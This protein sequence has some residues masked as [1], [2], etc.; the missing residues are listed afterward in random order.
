MLPCNG[1]LAGQTSP[2]TKSKFFKVCEKKIIFNI[3]D[4]NGDV[5]LHS[6]AKV[7]FYDFR[8]EEA[9]DLYVKGK[10]KHFIISQSVLKIKL[11]LTL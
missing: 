1:G 10:N 3:K 7:P 4:D 9:R 2:Y 8:L 5:V 11:F 6:N